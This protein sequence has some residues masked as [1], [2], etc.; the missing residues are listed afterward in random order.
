M[1]FRR[2]DVCDQRRRRVLIEENLG[3]SGLDLEGSVPPDADSSCGSADRL[4]PSYTDAALADRRSPITAVI[5]Q[6]RWTVVVLLLSGLAVIAGIQAAYGKQHLL[7]PEM[8]A[9]DFTALDVQAAGGLAAWFCS[10]VLAVAAFQGLQIYRLR[11][12]KNDDYRG[13]YRVWLWVPMVLF[14]MATAVATHIH[15]DLA[16]LASGLAN[17]TAPTE[18]GPLWP[19]AYCALWTLISLRLAFEL[20]DSRVSLVS[21]LLATGCYF[22]VAFAFLYSDIA[23]A[24]IGEINYVMATTT[25]AMAG[26]LATFLTVA[27]YGRHVYLDSQGVLPTRA[28]RTSRKKSQEESDREPSSDE[29]SSAAERSS[30]KQSRASVIPVNTANDGSEPCDAPD[31]TS[32]KR[33]GQSKRRKLSDETAPQTTEGSEDASQ[34]SP[35]GASDNRRLSKAERR[36][37]RKQKRREQRRKA[38]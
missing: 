17:I 20:R 19:L 13:R 29:R 32:K 36:R 38:A 9:S 31:R 4:L 25:F 22:A 18:G 21:L 3:E 23:V 2:N 10:L 5:P 37:L 26:H 6:R 35:D 8:W 28:P 27:T 11:R 1:G 34:E 16:T 12:H 7:P 15:H 30:R 14:F 33:T 24:K